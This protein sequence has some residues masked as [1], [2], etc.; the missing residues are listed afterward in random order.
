MMYTTPGN[1]LYDEKTHGMYTKAN[2]LAYSETSSVFSHGSSARTADD[3]AQTL[4]IRYTGLSGREAHVLDAATS[5]AAHPTVLYTVEYRTR[6]P[7]VHVY[8]GPAASGAG[9]GAE[10]ATGV[11]HNFTTC[12]LDVRV[13][14]Q[15]LE[16]RPRRMLSS[17]YKW[18]GSAALGGQTLMW[19]HKPRWR[20]DQ[21]VL[22]DEQGL[23]V[24]RLT[25]KCSSLRRLGNL[26]ILGRCPQTQAAVD[27]IVATCLTL[28]LYVQVAQGAANAASASSSASAA[29]AAAAA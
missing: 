14:G 25:Q 7:N 20:S 3:V 6:K 4:E 13:G 1:N 2:E 16:L 27:E 12:R 18:T 26:E 9:A 22:I 29:S 8:R 28:V 15:A 21:Y 17:D 24:A 5:D 10:I 19:D 23:P 11:Y